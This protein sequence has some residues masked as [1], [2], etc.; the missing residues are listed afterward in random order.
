MKYALIMAAALAFAANATLSY[1][2]DN[3]AKCRRDILACFDLCRQPQQE[4]CYETCEMKAK[5]Y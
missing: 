3:T 2:Q 1:A 4:A 5:A